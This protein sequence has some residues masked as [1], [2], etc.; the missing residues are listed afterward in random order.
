MS[1]TA[2]TPDAALPPGPK[3]V[4]PL[5]RQLALDL[6]GCS[7]ASLSDPAGVER[8]LRAA[9]AA[10]GAEVVAAALQAFAGGGVS[11]VLVLA[12]SHLAIHTWPEHAYAAVDAFMC[13]GQ[14]KPDAVVEAL[15]VAF[16]AQEHRAVEWQRGLS[17]AW[18]PHA[19]PG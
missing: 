14:T 18:P 1:P 8:A 2:P 17:A 19:L 6:M 13:G 3:L 5:G 7:V 16:G 9:A 11:G 10:A 12:E 15:G 4:P